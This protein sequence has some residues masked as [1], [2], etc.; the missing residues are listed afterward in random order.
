M[1]HRI[2]II[3]MVEVK[4]SVVVKLG[5]ANLDALWI[6]GPIPGYLVAGRR[7]KIA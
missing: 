1:F 3:V 7:S 5:A 6:L 2:P 4:G